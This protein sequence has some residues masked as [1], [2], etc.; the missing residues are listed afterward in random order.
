MILNV[1]DFASDPMVHKFGALFN[2]PGLTNFWG[3]VQADIDIT[4]IRSINFPPFACSDTRTALLYLDNRYFQASGIPITFRW[5][6]DRIERTTE[7]EG[8]LLKT[9]TIVPFRRRSVHIQIEV[10]NIG[11]AHRKVAFKFGVQGGV[12]QSNTAWNAP[13][14]PMEDDNSVQIEPLR[15]SLIFSAR[16]SSAFSLQGL[17]PKADET[18]H[19]S[20]GVS[21]SLDPGESKHFYYLTCIGDKIEDVQ[22]DYDQLCNNAKQIIIDTRSEWKDELNAAIT[23]NNSRFSGSMPALET[24]DPDISKLY[25]MGILGVIYFKRDNPYSKYGRA[26]DTLMPRYW[27]TVTFL[28]DYHLSATVHSLLDPL[29]MKKYLEYWMLLD[30]HKHFGTEYLKGGPAG[31]WYSVNDYAMTKMMYDYLRWN[32][33]YDWLDKKIGSDSVCAYL[34]HYV[35]NWKKFESKSGL[36]DYGDINNLLECVS[37]YIHEVASLNAANIFNMRTAADIFDLRNE[38]ARADDLR[39]EAESLVKKL[40]HLYVDGKGFWYSRFPDG[41]LVEVRHCYDFFTVI[42]TIGGD[43]TTKQKSEMVNFFQNELQT[44]T[45]MYALSPFDDNAVFSLR[46]DHQ[47][48][49]AYPAWP[50]Q[51]AM[52]LYRLGKVDLAFSWLKGLARSANQ[53]PFGQAHFVEQV[54]A[55]EC[56]GAKKAPPDMPYITDWTCSSNGSWA[57]VIIDS[58]FGVSVTV[59]EGISAKPQFGQF[60]PKAELKNLRFG[61]K[62]YHVTRSGLKAAE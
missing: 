48:T 23:P 31:Y 55:P 16:R 12:T 61:D 15:K 35:T 3:C 50:P 18:T 56:G 46:P 30:T 1:E 39:W 26:Y 17:Y 51:A 49:G 36:A 29:V 32:G 27:Q 54:I 37:T 9:I 20:L 45:W 2:P 34:D 13:L 10:K 6:P 33:D 8:L 38:K 4:G 11:G 19:N 25:Y 42:N 60:D 57:Q 5:F 22:N 14:P 62:F 47:W 40:H 7:H 52:A 21:L 41:G 53:G 28:W 43:L 24:K 44:P 59:K 58:I